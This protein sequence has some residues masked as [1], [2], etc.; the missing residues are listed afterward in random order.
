MLVANPIICEKFCLDFTDQSTN[1]PTAWLW[2]FAGGNPSTSTLQ[3]P[4]QICYNS[5]GTYD[6]T[7]TV[8]NA[9]GSLTQTFP[10]YITVFATPPAPQINQ[11]GYTLYSSFATSY[12]WQYNSINIP[13]ATNQSYTVTQ[14]GYYSVVV[15]DSHGCSNYTTVYILIEGVDDVGGDADVFITPNPSDGSFTVEL[16]N[17]FAAGDISLRVITDLGQEVFSLEENISTADWSR[18]IDLKN[19]AHGVYF[20]EI[21]SE[22][23]FVKKKLMI[24][25]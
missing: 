2:T 21:K 20:L 3:N 11:S 4:T 22:T 6:V 24:I 16:I 7:L 15:W 19:A 18:Q 12:Q 8:T 25:R 13:G 23:A 1:N 5:P 17:G 14:S 9:F 10:N